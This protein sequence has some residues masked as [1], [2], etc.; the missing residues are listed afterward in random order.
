MDIEI[1]NTLS[2]LERLQ[3]AAGSFLDQQGLGA[4]TAFHVLFALEEVVSNIILHGAA[5]RIQVRLEANPHQLYLQVQDDGPG[6]NPL[7]QPEPDTGLAL[8]ARPIGG[9]GIYL[10]RQLADTMDYQ[11]LADGNLLS[12][13]FPLP[14]DCGAGPV[15]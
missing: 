3:E 11:R 7:L 4:E 5:Q 13:G 10:T 6:F 8:D 2:E 1:G 14:P 15:T 12:L 9:L